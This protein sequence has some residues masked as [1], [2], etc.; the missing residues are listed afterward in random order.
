MIAY[1][2]RGEGPPLILLHGLGS[3][4]QAWAPVVPEVSRHREVIGLN[5]PGPGTVGEFADRVAGFLDEHGI[6][7]PEVAGNSLGGGIALELA[8]RGLVSAVTAFSPIGFWRT[9]G[10]LW[11]QSAVT[12]AR[13][14]AIALRP[15]LPRLLDT[16]PGRSV[17]CG[18]FF[19]DPVRVAPRTCL[20]DA[21][22][23]STW[24]GFVTTRNAMG[25]W[26]PP[27][28]D[29]LPVTIAWGTR[30][31]IL[32]YRTQA[33]RARDLLPGARHVALD[34]CGHVPFPDDPQRCA[35]LLTVRQ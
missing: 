27:A 24:P 2:R 22:A 30:D 16:R 29:G 11:C 12:A 5:L 31:A 4:R 18:L 32:P 15:L 28:L 26:R 10:R 13:G 20:E 25:R 3:R 21:R 33:R 34:G 19:A 23:L 35:E 7:R 6:D 14:G 1:E 9:P 8:G 17:L